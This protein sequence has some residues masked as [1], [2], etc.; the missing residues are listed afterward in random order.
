MAAQERALEIAK[1]FAR[2]IE[3]F[4][5]RLVNV[6]TNVQKEIAS[7]KTITENLV[8]ATGKDG[9]TFPKTE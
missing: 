5:E 7:L 6:E 9:K 1:D 2:L 3:V 4:E 8:A